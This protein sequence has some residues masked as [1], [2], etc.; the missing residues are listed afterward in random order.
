[1]RKLILLIFLILLL[2]SYLFAQKP[3]AGY[4]IKEA[5]ST[6][7]TWQLVSTEY[8]TSE[9]YMSHE[10]MTI[11]FFSRDTTTGALG[12]SIDVTLYFQTSSSSKTMPV[13]ERTYTVTAD[14]TYDRWKITQ[15]AIGNGMYWRLIAK[16]GTDNDKD[17]GSL[18]DFEYDGYP[19]SR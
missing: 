18:F 8:D 1:M 7:V 3:H 2:P 10:I 14:S 13:T 9:W 6:S 17:A 16:G 4:P 19:N 15:T 12:D 11:Y 5:D